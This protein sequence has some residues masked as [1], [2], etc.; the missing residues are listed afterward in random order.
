[1]EKLKK[2]NIIKTSGEFTISNA[3]GTKYTFNVIAVFKDTLEDVSWCIAKPKMKYPA[4]VDTDSAVLFKV[5]VKD[6]K[7]FVEFVQ[8]DKIVDDVFDAYNK[9]VDEVNKKK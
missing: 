9:Y 1:M 3:E 2:E 8:D 5:L 4:G 6:G 7:E